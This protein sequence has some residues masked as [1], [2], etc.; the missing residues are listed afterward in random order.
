[1]IHYETCDARV[2]DYGLRVKTLCDLVVH[3]L[4]AV[5]S[6]FEKLDDKTYKRTIKFSNSVNCEECISEFGMYLLRETEI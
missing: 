6:T 4:N 3:N 5:P 1:M 2:L